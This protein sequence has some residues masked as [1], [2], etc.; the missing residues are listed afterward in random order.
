[1]MALATTV[2]TGP[3]LG[4]L[5]YGVLQPPNRRAATAEL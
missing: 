3:L 4:S 1:L 5:G 2:M